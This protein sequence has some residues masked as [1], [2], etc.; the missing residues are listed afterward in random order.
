M[1]VKKRGVRL[2]AIV[3][4]PSDSALFDL[5]RNTAEADQKVKEVVGK[6]SQPGSD[7]ASLAREYSEDPS[8]LQVTLGISANRNSNKNFGEMV[9]VGFMNRQFKAGNITAPTVL[10]GKRYIFKLQ[11]RVE[12]DETLRCCSPDVR[13]QINEHLVNARK[14]LLAAAYQTV[15]MNEA[16]IQNF[17]A[18]KFVDN[19]MD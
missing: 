2:A 15:A 11:E 1:F 6:L 17:L 7:F 16:R 5:T 18:K 3:I 12:K 9:S 8:K 13:F 4:D 19:P 10:N 14:Q